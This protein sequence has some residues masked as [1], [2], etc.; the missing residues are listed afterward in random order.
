MHQLKRLKLCGRVE[1]MDTRMELL[2]YVQTCQVKNLEILELVRYWGADTVFRPSEWIHKLMCTSPRLQ[3]LRFDAP[4]AVGPV[5]SVSD[6]VEG[7]WI[8]ERLRHLQVEIVVCHDDVDPESA[9]EIEHDHLGSDDTTDRHGRHH[10]GEMR[11][12]VFEPQNHRCDQRRLGLQ[13]VYA[14]L[15]RL[16]RRDFKSSTWA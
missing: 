15:A 16:K 6:M 9:C 5:L 4:H 14:Q 13:R 3:V 10:S 1:P 11:N 7:D 8:C 2:E 12:E